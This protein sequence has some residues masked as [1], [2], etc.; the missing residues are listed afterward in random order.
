MTSI[1][2][3]RSLAGLRVALLAVALLTAA[4]LRAEA[5]DVQTLSYKLEGPKSEIPYS[6]FVPSRY[7][8]AKPS[9]LIVLLHGLFS[10]PDQVIQYQGITHEAER[11]GY[12]VVAPYG[13]NSH[14]WY[15]SMGP[16][17]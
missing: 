2:R 6:P 17:N 9:P 3:F 8:A 5:P 15:G 10:N 12:I 7:D 11:R 14:G 1:Q 4:P 16:G 13:Y